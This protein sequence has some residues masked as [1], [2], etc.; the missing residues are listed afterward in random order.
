MID[1]SAHLGS[2]FLQAAAV[3]DTMYTVQLPAERGWFE[4]LTGIASGLM[5]IALMVLAVTLTPAALSFR[6]SYKKLN[7][8]LDRIYGDINPIMRH[9]SSIA[10]NV[11]YVTTALRSDVQR[12][13]ATVAA[14]NQRI[15]QA[16]ELTE[17]RINELNALLQV[18]Q[19]EAEQLFVGTAATVRG[20]RTG[21]AAFAA[22]DDGTELAS[23]EDAHLTAL[24]DDEE[25][26]DDGYDLDARSGDPAATRTPRIRP[27]G[28]ATR[29]R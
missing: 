2:L 4:Q 23:V 11:D 3:R 25:E 27:R 26:D 1:V 20:V 28:P 13:N 16:V 6:K 10:D 18:V 7:L 9:A 29:R 15:N 24:T 5:T 17:H 22:A 8:L 12:I 19:E 21:A 14:A